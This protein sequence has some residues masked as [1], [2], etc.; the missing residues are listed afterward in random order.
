MD[1]K[2]QNKIEAVLFY[3]AEPVSV[4]KLAKLCSASEAEAQSTLDELS[5]SL[6]GRGLRVQQGAGSVQLVTAPEFSDDIQALRKE[7]MERELGKAAL[8]TLAI[9]A[10]KGEVTRADI[11]YV[12]GVN[13]TFSIRNLL[14]RGLIEKKQNPQDQRSFVYAP[15]LELL[16]HL[17][18]TTFS[19]LPERET[20]IKEMEL[21]TN[22]EESV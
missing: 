18:I 8:E 9:I 10:Y 12:R 17:G 7:E 2:L 3:L 4:A 20:F 21:F 1:K 6:A 15:S 14:M 11:D 5:E 22:E 16:S 19:E 13:S